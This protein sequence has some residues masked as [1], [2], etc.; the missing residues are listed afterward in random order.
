MMKKMM[1]CTGS[2]VMLDGE[3]ST[4]IHILQEVAQRCMLS[5]NIFKVYDNGLIAVVEVSGK[6][7][8]TVGEDTVSG[9]MFARSLRW[10]Y[11]KRPQ[12]CRNK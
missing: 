1:E 4:S 10:G 11:Q 7:G 6:Q 5:L 8:A 12:G 9:L 3:I 2:A